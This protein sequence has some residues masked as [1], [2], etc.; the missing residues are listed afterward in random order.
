[1]RRIALFTLIILTLFAS[2][3]ACSPAIP[4]SPS[5]IP[6]PSATPTSAPTSTSTPYST[7]TETPTSTP[8]PLGGT[9][10]A[11]IYDGDGARIPIPEGVKALLTPSSSDTWKQTG[12]LYV[13]ETPY[14]W[15]EFSVVYLVNHQ[16]IFVVPSLVKGVVEIPEPNA[17]TGGKR[18]FI[19]LETP[20]HGGSNFIILNTQ[21]NKYSTYAPYRLFRLVDG[22]VPLDQVQSSWEHPMN[23]EDF[24]PRTK[25]AGFLTGR[26]IADTFKQ[27]IGK[28]VWAIFIPGD[29]DMSSLCL[30]QVVKGIL[31]TQ[32]GRSG[33][34]TINILDSILLP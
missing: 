17:N 5:P 28:L 10:V 13:D 34:D 18:I 6:S 3:A 21:D 32:N 16:K 1:M 14:P 25:L 33:V 12:I 30:R 31:I 27:Y 15:G 23:N 2:L 19:V 11:Y 29:G 4:I 26:A 9:K 8:E 20:A 24:A 7:P 22:K